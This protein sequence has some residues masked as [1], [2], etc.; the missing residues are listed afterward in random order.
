[1]T[2]LPRL[3]AGL[4]AALVMTF[5]AGLASECGAA[6]A[7]TLPA[8]RGPLQAVDIE[9][10]IATDVSPS[11]DEQEAHLQRGGIAEAFLNPQ[12]VQAIQ[13]GSL[14]KIGVVLL[15]FSSREYNRIVVDWRVIS[16][17][18]SATALADAVR[19][20]PRTFGRHTSISD[21][22]ESAELLLEANNLEG[23]KKVIDI[24]GDGPN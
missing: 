11:I 8:P 13:A 14:G 3:Q 1:M 22:I 17:K 7:R 12:V 6:P 21:A 16:D 18:A 9:L 5:S 20:A 4:F 19:R 23:T 2:T 15:D 10:V 24:S